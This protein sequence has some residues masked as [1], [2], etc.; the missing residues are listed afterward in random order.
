[1][2][3][4]AAQIVAIAAAQQPQL[5]PVQAQQQ[6]QQ[7]QAQQQP[8]QAQARQQPQQAQAQPQLPPQ[9]APQAVAAAAT[10]VP[11]AGMAQASLCVVSMLAAGAGKMVDATEAVY[12]RV[13]VQIT[14]VL[15]RL[16]RLVLAVQSELYI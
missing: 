10:A 7:A 11:A 12:L 2:L 3:A 15:Y 4:R 8:Q 5:P 13:F 16:W 14:N 6:P 1:M 9:Q